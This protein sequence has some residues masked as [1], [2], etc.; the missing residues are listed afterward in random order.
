MKPQLNDFHVSVLLI[1]DLRSVQGFSKR[2]CESVNTNHSSQLQ[3]LV[4]WGTGPSSL[5]LRTNPSPTSP[6]HPPPPTP[7]LALPP[8]LSPPP[9]AASS[10]TFKHG[11]GIVLSVGGAELGQTASSSMVVGGVASL[12]VGASGGGVAGGACP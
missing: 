9:T 11:S 1:S 3:V 8:G 7:G 2:S 12:G 10:A 6:H 4:H 5:I